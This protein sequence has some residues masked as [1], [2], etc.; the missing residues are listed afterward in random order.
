MKMKRKRTDAENFVVLKRQ[1]IRGYKHIV[2]EKQNYICPLCGAD[3][4]CVP[5]RKWH[6]DHDHK[7]G[8]VRGALCAGCNQAEGKITNI[9]SIFLSKI[10]ISFE[11]YVINLSKYKSYHFS[12]PS[13]V[14]HPAYSS[15]QDKRIKNLRKAKERRNAKKLRKASK[16]TI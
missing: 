3:M 14:W 16:H 10:T 13:N 2:A 12:N 6:L 11:E 1:D 7:T 4:L 8:M 5:D 15:F 9:I